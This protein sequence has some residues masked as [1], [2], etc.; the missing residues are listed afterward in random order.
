MTLP[1]ALAVGSILSS[2][3]SSFDV[4]TARF[5]KQYSSPAERELRKAIY[6]Q[7][8]AKI[9]ELNALN[10]SATFGITKFSDLTAEEFKMNFLMRNVDLKSQLAG[11]NATR[12]HSYLKSSQPAPLQN[13]WFPNATTPVKDQGRCGSCWAFATVEQVESDWFLAGKSGASPLALSTQ[14]VIDCDDLQ[15]Y[16][17][18]GT[19]AG[20]GSGYMFVMKNGGL[21]SAAAYPDTSSATGKDSPCKRN[22][23]I[24]GGTI[25]NYSYAIPPCDMPWGDCDNQ[26]ED[27]MAHYIGTT[28]PLGVCVNA[29]NWQHYTGGVLSPT[30]CGGHDHASLDHCVQAVGYSGYDVSKGAKASGAAGAYWIIRNSWNT[31]WGLDG[32]IHLAMGSNTCGVAD[33]PAYT[34][35]E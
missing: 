13:N 2:D 6:K 5:G 1:L 28:G 15:A 21:A 10:S 35:I 11:R 26:D 20:G 34:N 16:G 25:K 19:Y 22:V 27:G 30:A 23:P 33:V 14:Q 3:V 4:F 7:N 24:V 29:H 32:F 9:D 17:C 12:V 31:N 8:L 18:A